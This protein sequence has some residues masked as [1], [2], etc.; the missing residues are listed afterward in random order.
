MRHEIEG[1][2]KR[3]QDSRK[4]KGLSQRDLAK[5][6]G[7]TQAQIS[8]IEAGRIDLRLSS[9]V[10]LSNALGLDLAL[11]PRKAMPL[12]KS[13]ARQV[14]KRERSAGESLKQLRLIV[15]TLRSLQIQKPKLEGL[16]E[17]QEGFADLQRF[18]IQFAE[19]DSLKRLRSALVQIQK[20]GKEPQ[21]VA[22]SQKVL[23]ELR[24]SLE[25]KVLEV[26][27]GGT[28]KPAYSLEE[29]DDE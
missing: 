9:F 2:A 25:R 8:R 18:H 19:A 4:A 17:L 5:L 22:R 20:P 14:T 3:L 15:E 27:E 16:A 7:I 6:T 12:V 10:A 24:D 1:I 13:L 21:A 29:D 23:M 11:V 26:S 28:Q